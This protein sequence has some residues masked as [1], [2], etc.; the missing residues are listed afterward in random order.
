MNNIYNMNMN[1]MN[2][3]NNYNN[4][5]MRLMGIARLRKEF[6]LCDQDDEL[7]Q[8]GCSFGLFDN[9]MYTWKVTMLGPKDSPYEGGIFTIKILFPQDYPSL[10][11]DFIFINKIYHLNV[12]YYRNDTLGHI[13]LSSLN[14]WRVRGKVSDKPVFGVKQ[15]LFDI[16]C[17]FYNQG[18]ASPY[19]EKMAEQYVNNRA[20]FDKIAKEWTE[21]Y[22]KL[23][24]E[25]WL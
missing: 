19:D 1:Q 21:K 25:Y 10:G 7:M 2:P 23:E 16:F 17:L 5:S 12:D 4:N 8:I 15:A 14:E 9:D 3:F 11:P 22:A 18:I 20:K 13:S 24:K 6:H